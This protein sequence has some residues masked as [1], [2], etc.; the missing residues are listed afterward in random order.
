MTTNNP[1]LVTARVDVAS[2]IAT[3]TGLLAKSAVFATSGGVQFID[4]T[5]AVFTPSAASPAGNFLPAAGSTYDIG[6]IGTRWKDGYFSGNVLTTSLQASAGGVAQ[7]VARLFG[8][9]TTF[10]ALSF[11]SAATGG[12]PSISAIGDD[13]NVSLRVFGQG[14]GGVNFR[15][16]ANTITVFGV[17]NVSAALFGVAAENVQSTA[18]NGQTIN[19]VSG[20]FRILAAGAQTTFVIAN[21]R[22]LSA[23]SVVICTFKRIDATATTISALAAANQITVTINAAATADTDVSFVV[24]NPAV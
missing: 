8:V 19:A 20:S 14:T 3:S 6:A 1:S 17:Q 22:V 4:A 21:N 7:T 12:S 16:A 2:P 24:I 18:G 10:N 23:D 15:N 5:G 13:A 9:A 11:T